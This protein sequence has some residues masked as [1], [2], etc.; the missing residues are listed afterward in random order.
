MRNAPW[1]SQWPTTDTG[2]RGRP[3]D[4]AEPH[5]HHRGDGCGPRMQTEGPGGQVPGDR[6]GRRGRGEGRGPR[7]PRGFGGF[8]PMGPMGPMGPGGFGP[9]GPG[10]PGGPGGRRGRAR[11]G[12]VRQAILALLAEQPMNGYQIIQTLAERTNGVWKPSPGAIYPAISQLLDEALIE[13]HE[14][15]GFKGF[16]LTGAGAAAAAE[17]TVKPWEA[18]NAESGHDA[19]GAAEMWQAFAG[20]GAALKSATIAGSPGQLADAAALLHET[21]RKLFGI[22]AEQPRETN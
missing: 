22:L 5:H 14:A 13:N 20:L 11:R 8:G 1:G 19:E 12:D 7:G 21:R 9:G 3:F 2:R 15:E 4:G 17:V 18:V 10:F 6:D 16:R